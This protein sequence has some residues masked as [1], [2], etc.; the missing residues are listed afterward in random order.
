MECSAE[1][2]ISEKFH[3]GE[4]TQTETDV[5]KLDSDGPD[6]CRFFLIG[7]CRF[8]DRCRQRHS[9][10]DC[11]EGKPEETEEKSTKNHKSRTKSGKTEKAKDEEN[12]EPQ[13][14]KKKPRMRT[15]D[16]V[17]SR[18]LW[19]TCVDPADF[20]V[21]HLDR[22]L[23]VLERPFC[24]FSWDTQV[25]DCDYSEEMT[26]PRHR[27]QYFSYKGQRVWDR[28]SRTDHVFG[29]TGQ[30]V[31]PPFDREDCQ[32]N[33]IP[34]TSQEKSQMENCV[35][36]LSD[37]EGTTEYVGNE[38]MDEDSGDL[39]FAQEAAGLSIS[40]RDEQIAL[41]EEWKDWNE[42]EEEKIQS[43]SCIP[44]ES[45]PKRPSG[46]PTHFI[47]IRVDS[48][49]ALMAFHRVQRKVLTHLP[50]SE[51]F[52]VKPATLHIT[53]CLLVLQGKA[54]V[55]AAADILRSVVKSMFKPPISIGFPL[56][57]KHFNGRVLFLPPGPIPDIQ[58][59][60]SPLQ[61]AF[62][63]KGWLHRH[64]KFP[65]YHLT[66]AKLDFEETERMF[67]DI[68][69]IK[70]PKDINFGKLEVD[71]LYLC[72]MG[73]TKTESDFYQTVCAVQ[74]PAV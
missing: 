3:T 39:E 31:L 44:P 14:L 25:C 23:G 69:S 28:D 49:A 22:F 48:P 9:T 45:R 30:T 56:K 18:I 4:D 59:L 53:L 66:L 34:D 15:A 42:V 63:K 29:S 32:E 71:K 35:D 27:I 73:K 16:D 46:S 62:K 24:D 40:V 17:I 33:A 6:I 61:E 72:S 58:N 10:T 13:E 70:L 54:E 12:E 60:N 7:R 65:T 51:K 50:K 38:Q 11:A 36:N 68:G 64:S 1:E 47:C 67:I 19:D 37:V 55:Q 43:I 2:E 8:G 20:V 5:A 26:I 21:G 52:W 41:E 57:L 74:L